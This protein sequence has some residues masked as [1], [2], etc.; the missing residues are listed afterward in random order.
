MAVLP[1]GTKIADVRI[2]LL[3][4]GD[5]GFFI[6]LRAAVN[7]HDLK[8]VSKCLGLQIL[9]TS[10]HKPLRVVSGDNGRNESGHRGTLLGGEKV[11]SL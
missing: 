7:H 10:A 1:R 11:L 8:A 9:E 5:D 4:L 6:L 2:S 3:K